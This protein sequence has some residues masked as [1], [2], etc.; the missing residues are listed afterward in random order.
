MSLSHSSSTQLQGRWPS[1]AGRC[2]LGASSWPILLR[3]SAHRERCWAG[4]SESPGACRK[5]PMHAPHEAGTGLHGM[6]AYERDPL[7][8]SSAIS[9]R[10]R[11][12][13]TRQQHHQGSILENQG[14]ERQGS[15]L[16]GVGNTLPT[17]TPDLLTGQCN[18]VLTGNGVGRDP[19]GFRNFAGKAPC[20]REIGFLPMTV[21]RRTAGENLY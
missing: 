8:L 10:M 9:D 11:A 20:V 19:Q 16:H 2:P 12:V 13:L 17:Q 14:Y 5:G 1:T 3:W 15:P 4:S 18:G 6:H 21:R 7:D